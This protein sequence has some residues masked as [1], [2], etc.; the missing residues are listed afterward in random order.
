M[1][2]LKRGREKDIIKFYKNLL[3]NL[4]KIL[5]KFVTLFAISV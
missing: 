3:N 5:K 1:I 2:L 4:K